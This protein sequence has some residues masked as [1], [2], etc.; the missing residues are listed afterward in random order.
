MKIG[1]KLL[2]G[3]SIPAISLHASDN[4]AKLI[5]MMNDIEYEFNDEFSIAEHYTSLNLEEKLRIETAKLTND[6]S[7]KQE[8]MVAQTKRHLKRLLVAR[9]KM[10]ILDRQFTK[11]QKHLEKH[12]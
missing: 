3:L 5:K 10:D 9:E 12:N 6:S 7:R 4:K 1:L 2:I 11:I 8:K